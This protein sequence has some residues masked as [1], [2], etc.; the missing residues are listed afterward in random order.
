V[1]DSHGRGE[2]Q[3]FLYALGHL[4]KRDLTGT[5]LNLS[6]GFLPTTDRPAAPIGDLCV[7]AGLRDCQGILEL[8]TQ[9]EP[10]T[11][12]LE[13]LINQD[14]VTLFIAIRSALDAGAVIAA[15]AG[16]YGNGNPARP[17]QLPARYADGNPT[18]LAVAGATSKGVRAFYSHAGTLAA[19]GGGNDKNRCQPG[20]S[21]D[22][23]AN[24]DSWIIS[25]A[26]HRDGTA[27]E[28]WSYGAWI[29][30]SFS[31][32]LVSGAAA[33]ELAAGADPL[34]AADKVQA[35]VSAPATPDPAL[36]AGILRLP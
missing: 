13:E 11:W 14:G 18:L 27:N 28:Y 33:L 17:A 23:Q 10:P 7:K 19:P 5:V 24:L 34:K 4:Q 8:L 16:N 35:N 31:T 20:A 32:P 9:P 15:A 26:R 2:L 6:L 21:P 3:D 22:C 25:A 36:G 30:T 1:L 12:L 29:G